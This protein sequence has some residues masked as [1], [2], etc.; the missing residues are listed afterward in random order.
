MTNSHPTLTV[1]TGWPVELISFATKLVDEAADAARTRGGEIMHG[2]E[3]ER[4]HGQ[5]VLEWVEKLL[6][7]ASVE[8]KVAAILHD[9]DRLVT[10]VVAGGFKGDRNSAEYEAHKKAHAQRSATYAA[11]KLAEH[12]VSRKIIERVSHLIIHHD[13]M[14]VEVA[15]LNDI[16]LNALVAADSFAFFYLLRP[17]DFAR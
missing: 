3:V 8:L 11:A 6:P 9:I 17:K 16:E 1:V 13:D 5:V 15:R 2:L 7:N 14:G 10:P 12:D 4:G